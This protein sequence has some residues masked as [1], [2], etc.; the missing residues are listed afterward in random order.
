MKKLLLIGLVICLLP[1]GGLAELPRVAICAYAGKDT[2]I[3][4]MLAELRSRRERG[5][6]IA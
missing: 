2:F 1:L 3:L 4:S 6:D 5:E